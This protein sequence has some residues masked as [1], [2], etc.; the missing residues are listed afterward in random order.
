MN[1]THRITLRL[2]LV[3]C[4]GLLLYNYPLMSIFG[5]Q[6]SI[7]NFPVL[8]LYIFGTWLLIICV[9]GYLVERQRREK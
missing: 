7:A 5:V 8:Y 3:F 9:I 4:L 1:P 6:S 2:A